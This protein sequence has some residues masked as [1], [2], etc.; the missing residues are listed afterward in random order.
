MSLVISGAASWAKLAPLIESVRAMAAPRRS[1]RRPSWS[2]GHLVSSFSPRRRRGHS[3]ESSADHGHRLTMSL[4]RSSRP[5]QQPPAGAR[6]GRA[7]A[8]FAAFRKPSTA[9]DHVVTRWPGRP[10]TLRTSLRNDCTHGCTHGTG[11]LDLDSFAGTQAP[12]PVNLSLPEDLVEDLDKVAGP[13]NR[14]AFAE[15]A[16]RKA[17]KREQSTRIH[18]TNRRFP[19]HASTTRTGG[20]PRTSSRG[21]ERCARRRPARSPTPR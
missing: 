6:R 13:R 4:V 15:E 20:H 16:L 5:P 10:L 18:R 1:Q 19:A 8:P 3:L 12:I 7:L 21:Y 2:S 9:W 17:I 14:S 11:R